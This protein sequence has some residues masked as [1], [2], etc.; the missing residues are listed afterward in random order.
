MLQ[1]FMFT[2]SYKDIVSVLGSKKELNVNQFKSVGIKIREI[3]RRS[4]AYIWGLEPQSL[5]AQ[6]VTSVSIGDRH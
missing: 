5:T 3:Q 1:L 6:T 2:C 4:S